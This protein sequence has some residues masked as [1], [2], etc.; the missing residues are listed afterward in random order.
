MIY[1]DRQD[2]GKQLAEKLKKYTKENPIIMALPR[3]GVILGYEV[4][5]ELNA[6]LDVIVPR[7]IGA[8]LDPEFAIGAIAPKLVILLNDEM[9]KYLN[10]PEQEIKQIIQEETIEMNRRINLYREDLLDIDLTNRTV[11]IVDD[12]IATGLTT[13]AAVL[14]IKLLNPK[15]IIL[16][17]PVCPVGVSE[18][19]E[20]HVDEFI[21]LN[22]RSDFYAVGAY[23]ENFDQIT[24]DEVISLLKK[25]HE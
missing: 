25:S 11:I 4:A 8:P 13:Q 7:K 6:P 3:G 5:K 19:F 15:K 21:C 18:K 20:Q 9:I 2:A 23:Y 14:S 16:A 22:I 12:G 10:I 17:V 1:K 24:D